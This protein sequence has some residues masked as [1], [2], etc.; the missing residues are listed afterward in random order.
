MLV[1]IL[2]VVL[3]LLLLLLLLLPPLLLLLLIIIIITTAATTTNYCCLPLLRQQQQLLLPHTA[4]AAATI[5]FIITIT[6][7]KH[8]GGLAYLPFRGLRL[9]ASPVSLLKH[10]L[11]SLASTKS[12]GIREC[13]TKINEGFA[14]PEFLQTVSW[15]SL[16]LRP[17]RAKALFLLPH[18]VAGHF[19][20]EYLASM[21]KVRRN[22]A[23]V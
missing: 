4:T 7:K 1:I 2:V 9:L 3:V 11:R 5:I 15:P 10:P 12:G 18:N 23:H 14:A 13:Y 19:K 16:V 17:L 8:G 6:T 22:G 21:H 20:G